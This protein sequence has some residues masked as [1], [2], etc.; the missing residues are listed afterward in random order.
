MFFS[1]VQILKREGLNGDQLY[2]KR[3]EVEVYR[4]EKHT[5]FK[6]I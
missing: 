4:Q 5:I 1:E 2:I 3:V 6:K